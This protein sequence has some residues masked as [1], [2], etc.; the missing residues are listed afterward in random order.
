MWN[1]HRSEKQAMRLGELGLVF[2]LVLALASDSRGE[3]EAEL[4]YD[5]FR[6]F[7]VEPGE[8]E[9]AAARLRECFDALV[10]RM[11]WEGGD[12]STPGAVV[13]SSPSA[14]AIIAMGPRCF[15]LVW[16]KVLHDDPT[17]WTHIVCRILKVRREETRAYWEGR[18]VPPPQMMSDI[19]WVREQI[20]GG[21]TRAATR[22]RGLSEQWSVEK[23]QGS[24]E[25]WTDVAVLDE[26][27]G[28]L[29]SER[30]YT[31]AGQVYREIEKLGVLVLPALIEDLRTGR[32]DFLPLIGKLTDGKAP[33]TSATAEDAARKC[34][35]W[36]DKNK[37]DWI[38][39]L[40]EEGSQ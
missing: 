10:D 21:H 40:P 11:V 13:E 35:E 23:G 20:R 3:G 17:F 39:E 38:V 6:E 16:D 36:W 12:G 28:T 18:V 33:T 31:G 2:W 32:Y 29:R 25:L 7:V 15:L 5:G 19:E 30:K 4:D 22:F 34:I 9:P 37:A 14:R 24:P 1:P 27:K 8:V 26:E